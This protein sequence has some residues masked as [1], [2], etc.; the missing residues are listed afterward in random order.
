MG[1]GGG[2]PV[3]RKPPV[4]LAHAVEVRPAGVE[5]V[6]HPADAL[7]PHPIADPK[8]KRE[9][10]LKVPARLLRLPLE[11]PREG[12]IGQTHSSQGWIRYVEPELQ[13]IDG[14]LGAADPHQ[15]NPPIRP[16]LRGSGEKARQEPVAVW[17]AVR[18]GKP[19]TSLVGGQEATLIAR[20][21]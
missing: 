18:R 14:L 4:E 9:R 13:R 15:A 2:D 5:A 8:G 19:V 1:E 7:N 16:L 6:A 11:H 10:A 3:T 20:G 17:L 12:D 21:R